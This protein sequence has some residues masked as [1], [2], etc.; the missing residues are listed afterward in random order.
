MESVDLHQFKISPSGVSS[1]GVCIDETGLCFVDPCGPMFEEGYI[2]ATTIVVNKGN[3]NTYPLISFV[4][5]VTDPSIKNLTTGQEITLVGNIPANA[6]YV[7]DTLNH[8][9]RENND[10]NLNRLNAYDFTKSNWMH[11]APGENLLGYY[12]SGS[13]AGAC[14]MDVRDRWI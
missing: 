6:V 14:Y 13:A 12:F 9:V 3:V 2:A 11:L 4:G 10:P 1:G 5:N 7:V 8:T